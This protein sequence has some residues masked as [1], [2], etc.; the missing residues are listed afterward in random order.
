MKK[1]IVNEKLFLDVFKHNSGNCLCRVN[2]SCPCYEMINGLRCHCG[3][4]EVEKI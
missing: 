4:F 3:V 1:I 2:C